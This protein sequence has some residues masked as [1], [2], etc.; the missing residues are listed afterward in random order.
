MSN[1]FKVIFQTQ[2][3]NWAEIGTWYTQP[4]GIPNNVTYKESKIVFGKISRKPNAKSSDETTSS[5]N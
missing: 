5:S 4:L 3:E 1:S 2:L